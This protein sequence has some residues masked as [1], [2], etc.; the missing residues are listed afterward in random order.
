MT[1]SPAPESRSLRVV[2]LQRRMR[3]HSG[4][5]VVTTNDGDFVLKPTHPRREE[6]PVREFLSNYILG[7]L[8]ISVP[9]VAFLYCDPQEIGPQT[10]EAISHW[11]GRIHFGSRYEST[12]PVYDFLPSKLLARCT[13]RS[14]LD[15]IA[16]V[17]AIM[18]KPT[19]RQSVFVREAE[20]YRAYFI[21]GK[22]VTFRAE[23]SRKC[24]G[25][26][27]G[28]LFSDFVRTRLPELSVV[29]DEV[30]EAVERILPDQW[31]RAYLQLRPDL[32]KWRIFVESSLRSHGEYDFRPRTKDP[33]EGRGL[34]SS[35]AYQCA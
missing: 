22:D 24:I 33:S 25:D 26:L 35:S 27:D 30:V 17:D 9:L 11:A 13:N 2:S 28:F 3:G 6:I 32:E 21:D 16:A 7:R 34:T 23:I 1:R 20:G 18:G 5:M 4:C 12:A 15:T 31:R 8:G 19:P 10:E 14:N 29:A